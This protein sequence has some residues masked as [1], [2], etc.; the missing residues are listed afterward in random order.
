LIFRTTMSA[1]RPFG[2]FVSPEHSET[3]RRIAEDGIVLLKNEN[4][5]FPIM[6]GK[7]KRI[8]IIGENATR[9]LVIGGGSSSLKAAYE[10]SP[11]QGL[12]KKYGKEHIVY[13]Q[14][15]KSGKSE[16]GQELTSEFNTDS[17]MNAAVETA[18]NADL[19]L[20]VG[21]LNKNHFQDAEGGDR[22][23]FD[24]SFG[25]N[26]LITALLKVN[27]NMAIILCSGN[28]VSMPW[29]NEV[30]AIIQSWYLGSEAGNAIAN[31]LSGDINPSGKLPFSFPKKL[32]ENAAHSFGQLSYPG[33]GINVEYKEDILV[34]YRW[35]DTK[36][37]APLFAF[38]HGLS[39][40]T[41]NYSEITTNKSNYN[42][43]ES[44]KLTFILKNTGKVTGAEATQI[45]ISD[46]KSTVFRPI[47]ELKAFSKVLLGSSESKLIEVNLPIKEWAFFNDRTQNWDIEPG[48]FT[49]LV[50]SSSDDIRQ[51][52]SIHVN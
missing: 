51:K 9:S 23:T 21:G 1:N 26:K 15:Y 13:S 6:V 24:L 18:R 41:F 25:Q 48:K 32:N 16:Y 31:V 3:A 38:G 8:A 45:Y 2:K 34:G 22:K 19:V 50:G 4:K 7:Y 52:I 35:F 17:L 40:T 47:K 46:E 36:K 42:K 30:P 49:I 33:D 28:A 27:K 14:G 44:V 12:I 39:Y 11:L 20:F 10:V 29:V 5:F 37:I 43:D